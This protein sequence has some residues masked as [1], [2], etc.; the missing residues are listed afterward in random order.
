MIT[1]A[2][3]KELLAQETGEVFC[4]LIILSHPDW[5]APLR[6]VDD[7]QDITIDGVAYVAKGFDFN[8][9]DADAE[10]AAATVTIEDV[11][12]QITAR[13][14]AVEDPPEITL[15]CIRRGDPS[16]PIDGPYAYD[17]SGLTA[18]T[19]GTV[20]LSLVRRSLLSY[21]ASPSSYTNVNFP[22]LF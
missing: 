1:H 15:A 17:L 11:D 4:N 18:G 9:P 3:K 2:T 5:A 22:G 14:Q 16:T 21:N 7:T 6:Y 20:K 12:R 10:D 8:P 19:R 13:L